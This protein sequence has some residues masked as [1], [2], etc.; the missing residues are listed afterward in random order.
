MGENRIQ[1]FNFFSDDL[2]GYLNMTRSYIL[3]KAKQCVCGQ[4]E[5]DYGS[6]EN[7]FQTISDLWKAYKG[8]DFTPTDVA[9]MMALL[10]IA[11]I[12]TGDCNGGLLHRLAGRFLH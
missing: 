7:N 3:Q 10:K 9:M 4:R 5:Q 6:P 1:L 11:R 12:K 2:G 8:I